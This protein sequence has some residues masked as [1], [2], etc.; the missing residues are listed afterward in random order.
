MAAEPILAAALGGQSSTELTDYIFLFFLLGMIIMLTMYAR[1]KNKRAVK[2]LA[3]TNIAL[4]SLWTITGLWS[5]IESITYSEYLLLLPALLFVFLGGIS[6]W[7]VLRDLRKID[8][9]QG[10]SHQ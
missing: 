6:V 5:L 10:N 3:Y 9:E 4:C 8:S 1:A 7:G 2:W